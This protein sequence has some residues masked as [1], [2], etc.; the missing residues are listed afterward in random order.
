MK[1]KRIE[2]NEIDRYK[3][4]DCEKEIENVQ[5]SEESKKKCPRTLSEFLLIICNECI[6]NEDY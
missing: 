2:R 4:W 1:N 5:L 6:D 3:C